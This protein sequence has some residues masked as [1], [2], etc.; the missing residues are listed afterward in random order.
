MRVFPDEISICISGLSKGDSPSQC[1][2][3]SFSLLMAEQNKKAEDGKNLL[4]LPD[5]WAETFIFFPWT[6]DYIISALSSQAFKLELEL[7][8]RFPGSPSCSWHI[9]GLLSLC[10]CIS[11]FLIVNGFVYL[12]ISC[13][14]FLSVGHWL[15]LVSTEIRLVM[16]LLLCNY[17]MPLNVWHGN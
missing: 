7:Y 4:F 17:A 10:N 16:S 8:H 3:A 11:W 14:F 9:R 2:W 1:E 15:V 5:C 6:G 12:C 13:W